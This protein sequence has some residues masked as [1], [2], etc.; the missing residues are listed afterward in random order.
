MNLENDYSTLTPDARDF[1]TSPKQIFVGGDWRE[2]LSGEYYEIVDPANGEELAR[3]AQA[4]DADVDAAVMAARTAFETGPWPRMRPN[5]R[6]EILQRLA[7]LLLDNSDPLSQMETLNSGKLIQNTRLFDVEFSAH[8][9]RY[10]SGWPSKT[11]GKTQD[12]SVPYMPI[13]EFVGIT[14]YQPVGVVAGITPWNVPLAEAIWKVAPVLATG[15]CIVLKPA[16]QTP[17]TSLRLAELCMEAGVPAGVVNVITGDGRTGAALVEHP[18][19]DKI[20][21]T[22]STEVGKKI[23]AS[24]SARLKKYTLELGGKSPVVIAKDADLAKAIPGAAW[25]I[26]GNHGQNCCAGSRLYVAR[27][28]FDEVIA[29][30]A[31]I[32]KGLKIGPGLDPSSELG[33]MVSHAHRD[34]VAGFVQRAAS[35]G[36]N[37]LCGGDPVDAGGAYINPAVISGLDHQ[38]EAV[39]EEIFGPV[40]VAFPFKDMDEAIARA[41]DTKYGLGASI[42]SENISTINRFF[43]EVNAGTIWVNNHNTLD[44]ALPFGGWKQSGSGQELGEEG[45]LSH[46]RMKAGVYHFDS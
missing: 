34:R 30:V 42:W 31:E 12:L 41:N 7:Q 37:L 43:N 27:D 45:M 5:Q 6:E 2:P 19:I 17:L 11:Y 21:F 46:L 3:I 33:P 40:L 13:G 39:Q 9:L 36:A 20:T 25:A 14:R 23:A 18:G 15:C 1:A 16:E 10:M 29:G 32:A 24:A 28:V 8:F 4:G 26:L 22:G 35:G 44:M 38:A